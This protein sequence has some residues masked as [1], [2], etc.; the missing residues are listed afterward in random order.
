MSSEPAASPLPSQTRLFGLVR[1]RACWLP[2]WRGAIAIL[3]LVAIGGFAI[4]QSVYPFLAL[5]A[6]VS[7]GALVVEGWA[8]KYALKEAVAEFQRGH[9]QKLYVTGGVIED[10]SYFFDY[11]TFAE[12]AGAYLLK[13]GFPSDAL[14]PVPSAAVEKDR[15][16]SSALALREWMGAH[17]GVPAAINVIS[18]GAHSRRTHKLFSMA[19]EGKCKVGILA[20]RNQDFDPARWWSSSQG[21][22]SVSDEVIAYLYASLC[23]YPPRAS[24]QGRR[25]DRDCD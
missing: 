5:N 21:F 3:A 1:C 10:E 24:W 13:S 7:A 2:T 19:F 9:Y 15:T 23:F 16:Y 22:R 18:L 4:A 25:G 12:L 6:P 11:K 14:Q 17:G 8:P 20:I